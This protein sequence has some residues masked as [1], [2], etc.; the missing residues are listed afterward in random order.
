VVLESNNKKD[1]NWLPILTTFT[2]SVILIILCNIGWLNWV[3]P[4][5]SYVFDPIYTVSSN[6]ATQVSGYV[7]T[8]TNISE[9]RNEY[10]QMKIQIAQYKVDIA[11]YRSIK[12]EN[13]D[14]KI[15]LELQN[16]EYRYVHSK[17]LDHIEIDY[18]VIN[19]GLQDGITNG[20]IVVFGDTFLGIVIECNQYTSIVRLPISKSSFLEVYII[21]SDDSDGRNILSRA[22]VNG[23]S[24]GIKI[25]NIGM[26]SGVENGDVVIVNDS[27]VKDN[28]VLGHIVGLS[29]DPATTTRTGYVSPT[30]DFYDLLNVFVRLKDV[31]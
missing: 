16:K 21:S 27:K 8:L 22:V 25:E 20:D 6:G 26:N 3:K 24:D 12:K 9:F 10:N 11:D 2:I 15:Q 7:S 28:L 18:M 4:A 29:K 23:S 17:V 30:I 5:L 31:D 13:D 1:G 14:L 19:T